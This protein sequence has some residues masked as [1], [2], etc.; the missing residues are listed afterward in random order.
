MD[1]S[2]VKNSLVTTVIVADQSFIDSGALGD[3]SLFYLTDFYTRGNV[4]YGVDGQPD[5]L[6]P[7]RGNYGETGYTYDF[8]NDVFYAPKPD[9]DW[10]LDTLTWTWVQP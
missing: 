10:V 3:P 7:F 8:V 1:Y 2:K 4:H 9:G 6:P 5:G